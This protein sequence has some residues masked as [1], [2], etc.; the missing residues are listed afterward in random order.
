LEDLEGEARRQKIETHKSAAFYHGQI[1][2]ATYFIN[3]L[4][5]VTLGKMDAIMATESAV[6]EMPEAGFGG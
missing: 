2:S 4:L 3:S 6:M 5:P 1:L